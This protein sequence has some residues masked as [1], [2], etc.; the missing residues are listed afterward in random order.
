MRVVAVAIMLSL[1]LGCT[2]TAPRLA[3]IVPTTQAPRAVDE[4]LPAVALT[5]TDAPGANVRQLTDTL[6][7]AMQETSGRQVVSNAQVNDELAACTETPCVDVLSLRFQ[8]AAYAAKGSVSRV[9]DVYLASVEIVEDGVSV[10]RQS[11]QARDMLDAVKECGRAAGAALYAHT[12][13]DAR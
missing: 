12:N 13:N 9:G 11:A 6:R 3:T 4:T 8:N 1:V 10:V 7:V 5:S 2:T